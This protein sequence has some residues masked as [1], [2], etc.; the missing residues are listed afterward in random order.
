MSKLQ[1]GASAPPCAPVVECSLAAAGGRTF[2]VPRLPACPVSRSASSIPA[3]TIRTGRSSK[4][5]ADSLRIGRRVPSIPG[6]GS[7]LLRGH[8]EA[9]QVHH[10]VPCRHEVLRELLLR[11]R[12]PVDLRQRAQ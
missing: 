12:G 10:L 4:R 11:V 2:P 3:T 1:R 6:G 7:P 8:I 5:A 9:V